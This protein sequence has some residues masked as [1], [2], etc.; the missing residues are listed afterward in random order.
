MRL[1]KGFL[2]VLAVAAIAALAGCHGGST[3]PA[4]GTLSLGVTDTPVDGAQQVV[5]AFTG[6]TLMGPNGKQSYTFSKEKTLDLLNLQGN[7]SAALLSQKT[8]PAGQYQW[9]RLDLDLSHSYIV[10]NTG[11]QYPLTIPSGAQTGLKLVSGFTVAQGSQ[12]NF[13]I[14]FNLRKSVTMTTTT[15]AGTKTYILKPALR[16][17]N[18]QQVGSVSGTAASTLT[19][20]KQA[21]S[22]TSCSPAVYVYQGT[23]ITP[24]GFDVTVKGATAPLTSATL[25]LNNTTGKYDY[26]VGFLAPGTYSLA[27]TCAANDTASA[28]AFYATALKTATVS[29]NQTTNVNFP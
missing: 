1:Y 20:N 17:I 26:T 16:L 23:G 18:K 10:T 29:S 8:V 15:G 25:T 27:V 5:V 14:D 2:G 9:I 7:A 13:V 19:V 11:N 6:V 4:N 28:T 3:A 24:E 22:S 12:M 21:I